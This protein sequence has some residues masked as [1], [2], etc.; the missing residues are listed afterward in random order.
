LGYTDWAYES[1]SLVADSIRGGEDLEV[2]VTARNS[3]TR[4]GREVVQVYLEAPDDDPR[5]PIRVLA[6]FAAVEAAPGARADVRL[7]VPAR[8]FARFDEGSRE[9][10]WRPGS[11]TLRAGRSSRDLRLSTPVTVVS[12]P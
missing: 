8:T 3:G 12:Y 7:I 9:W 10:V 4:S 6:A 11:Y 2:V 5:R 1:I